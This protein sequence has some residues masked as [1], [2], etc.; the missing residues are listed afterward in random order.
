MGPTQHTI[1]DN[2]NDFID[3]SVLH[4]SPV[5][6]SVAL[7]STLK[8][9]HRSST[10]KNDVFVSMIIRPVAVK[11]RLG[12]GIVLKDFANSL[13]LLNHRFIKMHVF[14]IGVLTTSWL[15]KLETIIRILPTSGVR[16]RTT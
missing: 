4:N 10:C 7:Q 15:P 12:S 6:R 11:S 8:N 1:V 13:E 5:G 2:F 14:T 16:F 3:L 9:A